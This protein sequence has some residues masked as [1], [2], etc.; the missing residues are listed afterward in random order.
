MLTNISNI[1]QRGGNHQLVYNW[2]R[3]SNFNLN[4]LMTVIPVIHSGKPTL[5][6]QWRNDKFLWRGISYRRWGWLGVWHTCLLPTTCMFTYNFLLLLLSFYFLHLFWKYMQCALLKLNVRTLFRLFVWC[7][8]N[9]LW[10]Y[11]KLNLLGYQ[12][13]SVGQP[14]II[15]A[16]WFQL[17]VCSCTTKPAVVKKQLW[18]WESKCVA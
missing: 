6:W 8:W 2:S 16:W 12:L 17:C 11:L 15:T 18:H 7:P 13:N 3:T 1:F 14:W 4:T 9:M 10:A 5:T